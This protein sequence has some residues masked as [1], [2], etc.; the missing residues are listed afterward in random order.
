MAA[1]T[2]PPSTNPRMARPA[3]RAPPGHGP[4]AGSLTMVPARPAGRGA[5]RVRPEQG[6]DGTSTE[7]VDRRGRRRSASSILL[8]FKANASGWTSGDRAT[9]S[10]RSSGD[11]WPRHDV[12]EAPRVPRS[13]APRAHL[14]GCRSS[15]PRTAIALRVGA[16]DRGRP[17]TRCVMHTVSAGTE[18][19]C[20]ARFEFSGIAR[21]LGPLLKGPLEAA[22][23]RR[24]AR[25]AGEPLPALTGGRS[26]GAAARA[27]ERR[28]QTSSERS[29]ATR[30][31]SSTS[32][33]SPRRR[34]P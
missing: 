24:R 8:D 3:A 22:R 4:V 7:P 30:P 32:S 15:R 5:R 11:G 9:C 21:Y 27:T 33:R 10:T 16:Q 12:R 34:P 6:R 14:R 1:G 25:P 18:V 19:V 13:R 28:A 2:T 26:P 23:G 20:T 17:T 31:S 29:T